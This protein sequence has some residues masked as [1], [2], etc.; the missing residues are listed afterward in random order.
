MPAVAPLPVPL[1]LVSPHDPPLDDPSE[2][3]K[4]KDIGTELRE[5]R[6][7]I[8]LSQMEIAFLCRVDVSTISRWER[9]RHKH[10]HRSRDR[11]IR[12]A[13]RALRWAAELQ[14]ADPERILQFDEVLAH[15]RRQEQQHSTRTRRET[16][17]M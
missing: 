12:M 17:R 6:E 2:G 10:T 15:V 3:D 16:G 7:L 5:L 1:T 14:E 13:L 9:G 4:G 8:G 11:Q